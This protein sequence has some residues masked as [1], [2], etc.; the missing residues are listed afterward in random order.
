MHTA[1]L[2]TDSRYWLQAQEEVDANWTLDKVGSPGEPQDWIE[3]IAVRRSSV[4]VYVFFFK[5]PDIYPQSQ[6]GSSR[7]GIDTRMISHEKATL[8]NSKL[9]SMESKLVYPPQNL[10]DLIWKAKP[11]KP[12]AAI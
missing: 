7:I 11:I 8:L 5:F 4:S 10:V 1:F 12:D 9:S 6:A 3:W 2:L